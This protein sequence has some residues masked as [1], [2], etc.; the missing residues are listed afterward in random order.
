[1]SSVPIPLPLTFQV[2]IKPRSC[3]FK[4]KGTIAF[5]KAKS[6]FQ[7]GGVPGGRLSHI[8]VCSDPTHLKGWGAMA[9]P[10][11]EY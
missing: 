10:S 8:Q 1:M 11:S 7:A 3:E 4:L 6:S 5:S 9:P 2:P